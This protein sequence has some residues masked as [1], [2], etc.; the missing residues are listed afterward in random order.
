MQKEDIKRLFEKYQYNTR[1]PK[2]KILEDF[3][4]ETEQV[5]D[6]IVNDGFNMSNW[7]LREFVEH[8]DWL[9]FIFTN[10]ETQSQFNLFY[11]KKSQ[12][13]TVC[14]NGHDTHEHAALNISDAVKKSDYC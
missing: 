7:Y 2:G 6:F 13:I 1:S 11:E 10:D 14:Y 12:R 8:R 3:S 4:D 9:N 5:I